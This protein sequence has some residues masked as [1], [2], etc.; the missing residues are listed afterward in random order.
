M[1][2]HPVPTPGTAADPVANDPRVRE[3]ARVPSQPTSEP[4]SGKN[5]RVENPGLEPSMDSPPMQQ[6]EVQVQR[7]NGASGDIVIRYL[8]ASGNL[9]L[10]IPSSQLLGLAKAVD[11][12]LAEQANR[13]AGGSEQAQPGQGDAF[14]GH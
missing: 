7:V 1:S 11:Q 5:S 2:I 10:Q 13:R 9:I 12:A 14:D 4:D 6:D 8:D 3:T